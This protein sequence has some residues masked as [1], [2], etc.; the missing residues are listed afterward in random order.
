[1]STLKRLFAGGSA[2]NEQLTAFVAAILLLLLA[3]EGATL[4]DLRSLLT[5][6]AF[7][8]ML[9][10][11][12][13]ALKIVSTGWRM[14]RYYLRGEEYIRRGP[15]H[16]ALRVLVAPVIVLSTL[17]L[18]GTGVLLLVLD[19]TQGTV[20]GLHKASFVVWVGATGLHVLAH[21]LKLPQLL[22]RHA[23]GAA[24]RVALVGG[25]VVAGAVLAMATLPS[26]DRLQD[27]M[28]GRIGLDAR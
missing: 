4:L 18:F 10:I 24:I 12:I 28:S 27:H 22:R 14:L 15:P 25:S 20:V 19:Q 1:M 13:V 2:G 11:P 16:L 9:L 26:A 7:V 21:A 17:V 5:V 3:V 23:P 8:G 6:H